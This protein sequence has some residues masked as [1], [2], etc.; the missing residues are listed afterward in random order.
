ME[1]RAGDV[2]RQVRDDVVRRLDQVD[3]VLVERVALDERGAPGLD[4]RSNR[5][6]RK[7]A[8]PRSSS[9]AVT[10]GARVEQRRRSA[11]RGPAR[12]RARAGRA[13]GSASARI[14]SRTSGSARKF[15]DRRVAG[16]QA[17]RPQRARGRRRV[18]PGRAVGRG[19][20]R[21]A[22][23]SEG[24]ASRSRPARSPAAN[25]R[26]PAAP[27]IAPL[28]VH[29][30]GR[31]TIS[32]MPSASASPASRA[33]SA[34]FAATPPP[35]TIE[36]APIASAARIVLVDEDVDDRV[37]EA[38]RE[39][40]RRRRRGAARRASSARPSSARR[41]GDDPAGR[42]LEPAE[43]EVVR[44]AEPGPREDAVA[45]RSPPRPRARSPARPDSRARAAARPC[46]T[47]RPPH[48]RRSGRGAGRSGGRAS[49]R[50]TCGR[51]TRPAR[52]AGRPGPGASAPPGSRSQAA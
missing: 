41:R 26:A 29:S 2:V 8:R 51:P 1:D 52:R 44:V 23:G 7:A 15:C 5:S 42:R 46:R 16:T 24:R 25:R 6:R 47:P 13:P 11:A 22:S 19:A 14:A 3:E 28:S 37:L 27:I 12:S 43:A 39:L 48:R 40:G 17:R 30:A 31:G 38:P 9:T 50:G 35:S 21:P 20:H 32:G 45:A 36:R 34:L 33:R 4:R 18:D 10:C 49:R